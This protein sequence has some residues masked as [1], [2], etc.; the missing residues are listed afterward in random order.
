[1]IR[2]ASLDEWKRANIDVAK[3]LVFTMKQS[4]GFDTQRKEVHSQMVLQLRKT[5]SVVRDK[6]RQIESDLKLF[7]GH[8]LPDVEYLG[9]DDKAVVM[10]FRLLG[11]VG[12]KIRRKQISLSTKKFAFLIDFERDIETLISLFQSSLIPGTIMCLIPEEFFEQN[13]RSLIERDVHKLNCYLAFH[14]RLK[15]ELRACETAVWARDLPGFVMQLVNQAKTNYVPDIS[16]FEPLEGEVGL[17]R[18]FFCYKS[19]HT[20][21]VDSVV[22]TILTAKPQEFTA[23]VLTKCYNLMFFRESM[24]D[25]EQSL[26][27]L[28]FFRCIFNRCYEKYPSFFAPTTVDSVNMLSLVPDFPARQFLLPRHLLGVELE[29]QSIASIFR[30]NQFYRNAAMFLENSM[31]MCNP[32]D[33]LF[34]VH[35]TLTGIHKAAFISRVGVNAASIE[36]IKRLLCFDDLFGLFFGCLMATGPPV[37]DVFYL[38]WLIENYTPK[39]LSP[40]FEYAEANVVALAVHCKKKLDIQ[41]LRNG[42]VVGGEK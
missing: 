22:D 14:R 36:D 18:C 30:N 24:D 38:S 4:S 31:Y 3:N 23:A 35:K 6:K 20:A 19:P 33:A 25:V 39:S 27:L 10:K 12:I 26:A 40:S 29:D 42:E 28:L 41:R 5:L 2:C 1:M 37:V 8:D 21:D 34:C 32:L 7:S 16:Y 9:Y 11:A 17:S 15:S 13:Y